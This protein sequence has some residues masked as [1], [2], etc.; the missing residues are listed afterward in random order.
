MHIAV[1]LKIATIFKLCSVAGVTILLSLT[2]FL[3]L[4]AETLPQVS[5]AIPLLGTRPFH[6]VWSAC[7]NIYPQYCLMTCVL[8]CICGCCYRARFFYQLLHF[9]GL[10][11]HSYNSV[12]MNNQ[13][14]NVFMLHVNVLNVS[15]ITYGWYVNISSMI[16]PD[17]TGTSQ[18]M[19]NATRHDIL[20]HTIHLQH[21]R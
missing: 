12:C 8:L 15:V 6:C 16:C 21:R 5:D 9:I 10:S 4:V 3:N 13:R 19:L 20:T 18:G 17:K 7:A 11:F 1:L 2:V 14:R